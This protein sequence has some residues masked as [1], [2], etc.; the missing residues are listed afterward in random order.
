[1]SSSTIDTAPTRAP[2][3]TSSQSAAQAG[4]RRATDRAV[5][6]PW[7]QRETWLAVTLSAFLPIIIGFALPQ[8]THKLLLATAAALLVVGVTLLVRRGATQP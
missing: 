7:Y 3:S 6:A 4:A 2:S 5:T 1:M 8:S